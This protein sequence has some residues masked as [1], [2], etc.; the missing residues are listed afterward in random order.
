MT[1]TSIDLVDV[2]ETN[3]SDCNTDEKQHLLEKI[4]PVQH[5]V[6]CAHEITIVYK[7]FKSFDYAKEFYDNA[8]PR[9]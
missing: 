9:C 3:D 4:Q 6:N 2:I 7:L 5:L 1:F 8:A